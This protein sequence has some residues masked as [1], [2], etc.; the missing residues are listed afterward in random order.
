MMGFWGEAKTPE[1]LL[2]MTS[3]W[4][5]AVKTQHLPLSPKVFTVK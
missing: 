5:C 4:W 2:I 1:S 3:S